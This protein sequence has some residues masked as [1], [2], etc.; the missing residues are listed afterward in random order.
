M[1]YELGITEVGPAEYP[2]I[3]VLRSTV[4]NEFGHQSLSTLADDLQEQQDVLCLIAHLEG[5]PIGFKVGHRDRAGVYYSK[6]G[7]VLK[8]YRR[9]G[10][11]TRMHQWQVTFAKARGYRRIWFNTFNYFDNMVRF[12]LRHGF[13]PISIEHRE[14]GRFSWK[15]ALDL[16]DPAVGLNETIGP[17]P[18]DNRIE[19]AQSDA[20][21]LLR[22]IDGN[23]QMIGLRYDSGLSGMVV[24]LERG[25]PAGRAKA[26]TE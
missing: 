19:I 1:G 12:G 8:D 13:V 14:L 7:G 15:F 23:Y 17:A 4:F 18:T 9:L 21:A 10:L 6:C 24:E 3:E 20:A 22:A 16:N 25:T 26:G 11:A 2:L 5:N